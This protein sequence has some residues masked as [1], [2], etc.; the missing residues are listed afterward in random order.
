VELSVNPVPEDVQR[1]VTCVAL[2]VL[3]LVVYGWP[4]KSVD[5]DRCT[6]IVGGE[7]VAAETVRVKLGE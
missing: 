4:A 1:R 3:Q 2:V 7:D 5:G 6:V